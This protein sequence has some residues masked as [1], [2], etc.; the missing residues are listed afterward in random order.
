MLKRYIEEFLHYLDKIRGYSQQSI[1]TY[2]TALT[3]MEEHAHF[4]EEQECW[5]LDLT[6]FR[7]AVKNQNAKTISKKLSA[8]RSFAKFLREQKKLPLKV[9][10]DSSIKVA[11]T[12]PKPV[13]KKYIDQALQHGDTQVLMMIL[14]TYALG[15]R[16]SELSS[17]EADDVGEEWA[18]VTGKGAKTRTI[19]VH[20]FLR[21]EIAAYKQK[22]APKRF[23]FEQD[24]A[25][26]SQNSI[27]YRIEKS[28][29]AI[30]I[31]VT[32]HQL[33]HSFATDLLEQGAR[34]KDV[35]ELLGH[36]SLASTQIYTKLSKAKKLSAYMQS[37]PLCAKEQK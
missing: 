37:H 4:Y 20:P 21:G 15:L 26:L 10:A 11:Q 14:L 19:P 1:R 5:Q 18:V 28:F 23:F 27:R 22:Y 36:E 12:L 31:K 13:A 9:L 33:R 24:G 32:P 3:Q 30:G 8:V 35:S 17:L 6:P 16:I 25:K 2:E 34:I 7:I 29:A